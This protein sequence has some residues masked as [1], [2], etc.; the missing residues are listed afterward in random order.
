MSKE[1]SQNITHIGIRAHDFSA[2]E[3][4]EINAFDTANSTTFEMPFEWEVTLANGL[5]WKYEKQIEEHEFVIPNYL[6][7]HPKDILLLEE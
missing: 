6:K 3:K 7:V 2:A 5:W 4:D 1:V